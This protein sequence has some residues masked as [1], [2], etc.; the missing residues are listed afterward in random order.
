MSKI[1][2][3]GDK[4][5]EDNIKVTFQHFSPL[6]SKDGLSKE[7]LKEGYLVDEIPDPQDVEGA[8]PILYYS[9]KE[10]KCYWKYEELKIVPQVSLTEVNDKVELLMQLLLE[11]EGLL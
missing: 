9:V 10:G 8:I 1:F 6:D 4:V 3:R 5:D 11:S 2:V 7:R